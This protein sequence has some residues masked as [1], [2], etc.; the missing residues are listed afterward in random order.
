M[1]L[2]VKRAEILIEDQFEKDDDELL[3]RL[4][5]LEELEDKI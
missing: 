5:K 4:A 2:E 3:A 1:Q